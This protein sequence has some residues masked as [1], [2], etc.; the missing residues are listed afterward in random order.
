M[1][2]NT[3]RTCEACGRSWRG[4]DA[5][6]V[7]DWVNVHAVYAYQQDDYAGGSFAVYTI[8]GGDSDRSS[9]TLATLREMGIEVRAE[10][11]DFSVEEE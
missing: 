9:V 3:D 1:N 11:M 4:S 7:C 10:L 6:P 2:I 8:I 5:C